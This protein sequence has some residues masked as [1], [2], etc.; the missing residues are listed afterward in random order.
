MAKKEST[1]KNMLVSLLVITA[2]SGGVLGWVYGLTKDSIAKVDQKKNEDAIAAVLNT[3]TDIAEF[4]V[5]TI[6][7]L[8]YNLAY[9]A[10]GGFIGAAVKTFSGKGFGGKVSLMV[11]LLPDGT[12]NKV[13]VLSQN[14]TPG[15]G[16]NMTNPK[17]KDQF[18]GKNPQSFNLKVK[19]DG[20][21]VDAITAATISSRAFTEAIKTACDGFE[22]NKAQF[23]VQTAETTEEPVENAVETEI[24]EGGNDNE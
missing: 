9:D 13:S 18:D 10:Q 11:G 24:T 22:A 7:E 14:E 23:V 6:D 4:K 19:K 8:V 5:D 1:L 2:V 15:L 16:A 21:D 17:F 12:I 3:G 20:G